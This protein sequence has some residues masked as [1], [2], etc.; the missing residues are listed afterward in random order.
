M[1][2]RL[3]HDSPCP[4]R[5]AHGVNASVGD[6]LRHATTALAERTDCPRI[7]AEALLAHCLGRPRSWLFAHATEPI[8][9]APDRRFGELLERRLRGEPLAYLT[10]QREFWSLTLAV[11]PEVLIPRPETEGLVEL[12]LRFIPGPSARVADLGTGSGA[13]ALALASERPGWDISATDVSPEALALARRNAERLGLANIGFRLG[14][15]CR[16]LDSGD[17]DLILANPP[18]IADGDPAVADDVRTHEPGLA[19]YAGP[20]GL[21]CLGRIIDQAREHLV[22]TGRLL[23]EHGIGQGPDLHAMLAQRGYR[24]IAHHEDLSGHERIVSAVRGDA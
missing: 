5:R 18:Y 2:A 21:E 9:A 11:G 3:R 10:G 14:D 8:T 24:E 6:R 17:Y 20:G 15:W 13:I 16:A 7:E 22:P 12:A 4:P 23:L 1:S 19:L